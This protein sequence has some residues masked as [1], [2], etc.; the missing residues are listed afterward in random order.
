MTRPGPSAPHLGGLSLITLGLACTLSLGAWAGQV[1]NRNTETGAVSGVERHG[2]WEYRGI[3]YAAAP[4]GPFRWAPPQAPAAWSGLRDGSAFGSACPQEARFNL[5]EG[6][7]DEDCLS[8]NVSTPSRPQPGA[9]LPVLL[10]IHGGAFVGG[11][12]NLYRLDKLATEGKMVVVS[13][14]YRLGAFGFMSHP[15]FEDGTHHNGNYG[16]EDQRM[17]MAWVQRN[18]QNFGGDPKQVTLAGESAGAGSVCMHLSSAD[19]VKGLFQQAI[20]QSAGCLQ[21]MKTVTEAQ[22]TGLAISEALNCHG[23]PSEV[24]QC[25]RNAPVAALLKQ[26]G[27]YAGQHPE[28]FIPFAPVTG[29]PQQPNATLPQGTK[30]A[31][32]RDQFVRVP[33]MMGG[34]RREVGLYVGY[35]WQAAQA[36]HGLPLDEGHLPAWLQKF[37]G[38]P[39]A[40]AVL[41]RYRPEQGWPSPKAVPETLGR[42]LS[43]YTPSIGINNCLYLH[44][45]DTVRRYLAQGGADLPIYQFEFADES[46]PVLGV[47]IAAP[48]PDFTLGAVH[49][50]ELNYLFPRLSN[51]RK[52]NAPDLTGASARLS[53]QMVLQWARFVQQGNPNGKGLPQW[54]VY[55]GGSSVMRLA[56]GASAAYNA[57]AQH[58]CSAFWQ[59]H[60]KLP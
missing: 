2:A 20:V 13:I 42:I 26:Q 12:S 4:V 21:P 45:S 29:T 43:D 17:A 14:N 27:L 33:L 39:Q 15:A 60:F 56:P 55:A 53:N 58:Q 49:S 3:P 16:L 38:E 50:T 31:L 54:P 6:S 11:S 41:A 51:T 34:T 22:A 7:T 28:D 8:L 36:G 1:P 46:A 9:K 59:Q 35:F 57:D 47:G 37:Y 5:T 24:A 19:Q 18:I 30:E 48:Y 25:L 40:A 10:W 23:S 44:T 52:I 32:Q